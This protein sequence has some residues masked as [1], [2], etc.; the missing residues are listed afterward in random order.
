MYICTLVSTGWFLKSFLEG[1][2]IFFYLLWKCFIIRTRFLWLL[3]ILFSK[4]ML[5]CGIISPKM[6]SIF[7]FISIIVSP[8]HYFQNVRSCQPLKDVKPQRR[9]T[10]AEPVIF[11]RNRL[12][13][14]LCDIKSQSAKTNVLSS[15]N[16]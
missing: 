3:M 9:W 12:W 16:L 14:G 2:L 7:S 13:L 5:V 1:K 15:S 4:M 11:V 10:V 8:T 6:Y